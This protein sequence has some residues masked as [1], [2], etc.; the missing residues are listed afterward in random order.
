MADSVYVFGAGINR[1]ISDWDGL[2]PPLS[3][4]FFQQALRHRR[5]GD[6]HYKKK[7]KPVFEYI[8]KYWK[9]TPKELESEPF[10]IEA[11][12]TLLEL[13]A[14]EA[15]SKNDRDAF[16][17]MAE[18]NYRL[19]VML[20]EYLSGFEHFIHSSDSFR[21]LGK[22]IH[23]EKPAVL[24]FNY[25]TL[26]ESAIE[27]ASGVNVKIPPSFLGRS[28]ESN[29]IPDDELAYSHMNWNRPLGY[30]VKFDEV[31]LHRAGTYAF[32]AGE[33][34]YSN[35]SNKLYYP[36]LLKLHGSINWFIYSEASKYPFVDNAIVEQ[37]KGKTLLFESSWWFNQ[38][39][40]L[41]GIII[42]PIIITPVV[43]KQIEHAPI[44]PTIW[45]KAAEELASCKRLIVGGYSFP[46]A[47]FH[48][49]RLFLEAFFD[50]SP[51]E[52]AIINPDTRI[53]Q[54]VKDLCHFKKP[55]LVC[56]D[57]DEFITSYTNHA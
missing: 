56:K 33:R 30:G 40:D 57:L 28:P 37:K 13:Q 4:D 41:Y 11:C 5:I 9:L 3:T 46:P 23:D 20:A 22:I 10:D 52:I 31:Q 15:L 14:Q 47:D 18:T 50:H 19:T 12:F 17:P 1:V 44:I 16:I 38:P 35:P 43:H 7:L 26:L 55:V 6:E 53:V 27:S 21:L 36:P 42:E 48:T 34:F 24:T 8:A 25:D 39:P 54:L 32:A 49:R 51:E 45:Q 2:V 29:D